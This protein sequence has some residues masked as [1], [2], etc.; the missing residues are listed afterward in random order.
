[1]TNANDELAYKLASE[2]Q[3]GVIAITRLAK[4]M[5]VSHSEA[6]VIADRVVKYTYAKG[7]K[8]GGEFFLSV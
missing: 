6:L 8:S 7:F 4:R 3:D 2:A 1:M 5:G